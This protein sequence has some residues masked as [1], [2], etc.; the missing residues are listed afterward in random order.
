[1]DFVLVCILQAIYVVPTVFP[2]IICGP[3]VHPSE[4]TDFVKVSCN[5]PYLISNSSTAF[6]LFKDILLLRL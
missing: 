1:M 6:E 3:S 5:T 4:Y 2:T